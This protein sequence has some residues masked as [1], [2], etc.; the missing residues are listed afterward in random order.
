MSS[1]DWHPKAKAT[2]FSIV[3]AAFAN[4]NPTCLAAQT[5]MILLFSDKPRGDSVFPVPVGAI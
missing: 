1:A 5:K 3:I 2:F 4:A